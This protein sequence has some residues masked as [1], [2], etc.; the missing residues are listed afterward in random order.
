MSGVYGSQ[1]DTIGESAM[2]WASKLKLAIEAPAALVSG[3]VTY[4]ITTYGSIVKRD[5]SNPITINDLM[6]T[7]T[8]TRRFA[9]NSMTVDLQSAVVNHDLVSNLN[10]NIG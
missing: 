5:E 1:G 4:G 7:A 6:R 8:H 3:A 2:I 9:P 10:S